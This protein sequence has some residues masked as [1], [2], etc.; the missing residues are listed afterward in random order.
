M[1]KSR[2]QGAHAHAGNEHS[3]HL[4]VLSLGL[5][6]GVAWGVSMVLVSVMVMLGWGNGFTALIGEWYVGFGPT[7]VGAVLGFI[8]GFIDGFIGGVVVAWLYNK[9]HEM[10]C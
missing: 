1:A 5:S 8:Y 2:K 7:P 4:D 6:L 10:R 9:F 3:H